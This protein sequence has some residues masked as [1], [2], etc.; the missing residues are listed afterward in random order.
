MNPDAIINICKS[1]S[2]ISRE[3]FL[4]N[5]ESVQ[6]V[7]EKNIPGDIVEI[8]VWKGGSILSMMLAYKNTLKMA[9]N[10]HLYDTFE[11]MTPATTDDKD[12]HNVA[13]AHIVETNLFMR[14]ISPLDEVTRNISR[15]T[16]IVPHYHVGDILKNTYFPEKIAVLRL[17]TDWYE[18]TKYEL[19]NF[20]EL[21]SPGGIVII[22]DYGHWK[23]CKKAVD[24]FLVTH[25]GIKL[26]A[27]DYTGRYFVKPIA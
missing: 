10:I 21:V 8:G 3:R 19:D 9:R 22:D 2:M 4:N 23:G 16:D 17:D 14:C 20:Y 1:Y 24:E 5:I 12:L 26:N 25:P 13:A 18:S 27:I 15:H 6:Y 7:E 11:G